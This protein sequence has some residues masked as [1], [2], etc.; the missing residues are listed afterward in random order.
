ML[1]LTCAFDDNNFH[2]WIEYDIREL[3][4]SWIEHDPA[5]ARAKKYVE[6]ISNVEKNLDKALEKLSFPPKLLCCTLK[7]NHEYINIYFNP[8]K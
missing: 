1:M 3:N 7:L 8:T 5:N 2:L 6:N 4:W